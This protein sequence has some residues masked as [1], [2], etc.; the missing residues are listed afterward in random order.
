[1]NGFGSMRAYRFIEQIKVGGDLT[2]LVYF[3][4]EVNIFLLKKK[5][6]MRGADD[7]LLRKTLNIS[8]LIRI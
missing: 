3:A 8:M 5:E 6:S 7:D 1:M 4:L 2:L